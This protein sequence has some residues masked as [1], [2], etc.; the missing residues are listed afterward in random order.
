MGT[1][2]V[3]GG[4]GFI[5]THLC[6]ALLE[7]GHHVRVLDDF[8][9]GKSTFSDETETIKAD[10]CDAEALARGMAGADGCF[11]LAAI[12]DVQRCNRDWSGSHRVNASGS[13]AVF[14]AASRAGGVPVAWASSA[15]VYGAAGEGMRLKETN[16]ARPLGPYGADKLAS[17]HHGSVAATL[18]GVGSIGHRFFNVY[19]PGQ[20]PRSPYSGVL[21]IFTD[22]VRAGQGVTIFGDG[23]QTRDF[24]HVRDVVRVL[25]ASAAYLA[26]APAVEARVLNVCT[27]EATSLRDILAHLDAAAG[28]ETPVTFG[29]A[30]PGDIRSSCGDPTAMTALLG[31]TAQTQIR[32][33]LAA[34]LGA[35]A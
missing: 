2:L 1:Y 13:V 17:E 16:P 8:S 11:H 7:A 3:T 20:D 5:G 33:G 30:R 31:L 15:A 32:S 19:G 18:F 24:I 12:A 4:A 6:R 34:L 22:R 25:L 9:T 21:S 28:R 35:T 14:E 27:G 10:I 29:A 23:Q 26:A